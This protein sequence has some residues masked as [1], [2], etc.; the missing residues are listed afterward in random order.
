[1]HKK[2]NML[3]AEA[4]IGLSS[5]KISLY[6]INK[7]KWSEPMKKGR[8]IEQEQN[9]KQQKSSASLRPGDFPAD[10]ALIVR[11]AE[12]DPLPSTYLQRMEDR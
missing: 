7:E 11:S 1:M 10:Y 6:G 9:D 4:P 8:E 2:H 5:I 3:G 12:S